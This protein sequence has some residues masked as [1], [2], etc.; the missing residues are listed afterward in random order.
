VNVPNLLG[1]PV[2]SEIAKKHSKTPAQVLLRFLAQN[3][4]VVI[5]KS[6]SPARLKENIDVCLTLP[7]PL[8]MTCLPVQENFIGTWSRLDLDVS[9]FIL[10]DFQL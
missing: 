2:V 7:K 5:P 3:E 6:V 4:L 10:P 1:D 8:I 9:F